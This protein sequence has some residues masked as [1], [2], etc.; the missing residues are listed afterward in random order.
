ML[1][2]TDALHSRNLAENEYDGDLAPGASKWDTSF[3]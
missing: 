2:V 1:D 3:S